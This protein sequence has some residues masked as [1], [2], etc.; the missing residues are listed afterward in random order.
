MSPRYN[1][2]PVIPL[3]DL[4]SKRDALSMPFDELPIVEPLRSSAAIRGFTHAAH[5]ES[6]NQEAWAAY[7]RTRPLQIPECTCGERG[8]TAQHRAIVNRRHIGG[9]TRGEREAEVA[10]KLAA[11]PAEFR[12]APSHARR[13]RLV[14]PFVAGGA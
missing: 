9:C 7:Q 8:S 13:A 4:S 11:V 1:H 6:R 5:M 10:R 3:V 12:T 2:S 14:N